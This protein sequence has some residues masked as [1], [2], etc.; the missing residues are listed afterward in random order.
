[1]SIAGLPTESDI[2]KIQ[3]KN[4]IVIS[5]IWGSG[6]GGVFVLAAIIGLTIVICK[7]CRRNAATER[8]PAKP[9]DVLANRRGMIDTEHYA[10]ITTGK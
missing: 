8:V 6:L 5:P 1:M 4:S 7:K 9:Y 2:I 10:T 3:T